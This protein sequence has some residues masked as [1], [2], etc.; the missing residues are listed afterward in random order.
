V[1]T[2]RRGVAVERFRASG[3]AT[4]EDT[5]ILASEIAGRVAR[6]FVEDGARLE[7]GDPVLRFAAAPEEAALAAAEARRAEAEADLGRQRRLERDDV[8]AEAQVETARARA[9]AARAEVAQ[10]RAALE[11]HTVR[12]PFAGEIGFLRVSEGAYLAPGAP[13]VELASVDRVRIRFTLPQD[14]AEAARDAGAVRLEGLGEAC[15]RAEIVALSPLTAAETRSRTFEAAPPEACRLSPGAFVTVSAPL[16]RREDAVFAPQRAVARDGFESW[17]FRVV[18]GP[19][20]PV[21]RRTPVETGVFSGEEIEIR[22]GLEA[23]A[24]VVSRG[25]QKVSD[26]A[27]LR[28]VE[29][30]EAAPDGPSG[31]TAQGEDRAG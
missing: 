29:E 6:I 7:P 8:V 12:A 20:G 30:D 31:E 2:A 14:A 1:A 24:R 13:I 22:G 23:G 19:E 9:R 10:A 16:A 4:A 15:R 11:D 21:A 18:D 17:V 25:L 5:V 28:I 26:G 3:A 27:L